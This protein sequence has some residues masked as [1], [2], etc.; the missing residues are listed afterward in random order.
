MND[1]DNH[2]S[3]KQKKEFH[4]MIEHLRTAAN[5]GHVVAQQ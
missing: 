2:F 4:E 3:K 1:Q 5:Q